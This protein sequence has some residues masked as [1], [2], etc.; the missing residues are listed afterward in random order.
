MYIFSY[1]QIDGIIS[2]DHK[3]I[4][5]EDIEKCLCLKEMSHTLKLVIVQACQGDTTGIASSKNNLAVDGSNSSDKNIKIPK[6]LF[7]DGNPLKAKKIDYRKEFLLF[8]STMKGYVAIR[9]KEEGNQ[10][11]FY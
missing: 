7:A 6:N 1:Q 2:S 5:F 4:T 8:K 11:F 3:K 10:T 9:H